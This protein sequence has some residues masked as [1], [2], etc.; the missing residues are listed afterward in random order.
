MIYHAEVYASSFCAV[1]QSSFGPIGNS[2]T[3]LKKAALN[4]PCYCAGLIFFCKN[5]DFVFVNRNFSR[6]AKDQCA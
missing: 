6:Y 3:H 2:A 5:L 1:F 4:L